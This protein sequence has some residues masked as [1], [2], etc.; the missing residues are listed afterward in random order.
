MYHS[1]K[2]ARDRDRLRQQVL[3]GLDWR[4]HRI[5]GTAWY[6]DRMGQEVRLRGAIDAV[7][8]GHVNTRVHRTPTFETPVVSQEEVDFDAPPSWAEPYRPAE[9][10]PVSRRFEIHSPEARSE[11]RRLI[12]VVTRQE[13][14]VHKDRVLRAIRKGWGKGRAGTRIKDAFGLAVGDLTRSALEADTRG[15]L[16][17]RLSTLATVRIPT[18]DPETRREIR[19]LPAEELHLAICHIVADAHA[20]THEDLSLRVAH[21]FGWQRRGPDIQA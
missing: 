8:Q 10:G 15:F 13:G 19:H 14:P 5:W 11:L 20:I 4:I 18:E 12:E 2:V 21:L 16:K 1:S 7:L 9:L 6:R 3:E 17:T